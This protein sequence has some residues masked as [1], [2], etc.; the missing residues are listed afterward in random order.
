MSVAHELRARA[1]G[2][3]PVPAIHPG[4]HVITA[5]ARAARLLFPGSAA[6]ADHQVAGRP[7]HGWSCTHASG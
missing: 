2:G 4:A 5:A 7:S 3:C 1:P 6:R